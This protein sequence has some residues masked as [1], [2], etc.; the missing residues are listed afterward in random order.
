MSQYQDDVVKM[1]LSI[2]AYLD[3][4]FKVLSF[5]DS[6]ERNE[7]LAGVKLAVLEAIDADQHHQQITEGATEPEPSESSSKRRKMAKFLRT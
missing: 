6:L 4:R 2:A 7:V 1:K 3:L 5:I